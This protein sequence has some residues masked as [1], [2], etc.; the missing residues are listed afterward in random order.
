MK[1]AWLNLEHDGWTSDGRLGGNFDR[2]YDTYE[3]LAAEHPDIDILFRQEMTHSGD[4]GQ[5]LLGEA[6][7]ITGLRG[8]IAAATNRD[9][10]NPPGVAFNPDRFRFAGQYQVTSGWQHPPC[11]VKV[12]LREVENVTLQLVSFHLAY[13]DPPSRAKEARA[14]AGWTNPQ[15]PVIAA[16]DRNSYGDTEQVDMSGCRDPAHVQHRTTDGST[17]DREPHRILSNGGFTALLQHAHTL[18]IDEAAAGT[19]SMYERVQAR[20]GP[21]RQVDER[22]ASGTIHRSIRGARVIRLPTTD[23]ALCIV[24]SDDEA[25]A[26]ELDNHSQA[27]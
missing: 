20:Q 19:A 1:L 22:Y 16:G 6:E 13:N 17:P 4:G 3:Y 26:E 12:A 10:P 14:L 21:P 27:V 9:S 24:E 11:V 7:R 23:H 8:F 18:G 2:W 15:R 5:Y 25:F